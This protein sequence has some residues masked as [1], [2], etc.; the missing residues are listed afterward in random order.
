MTCV[1][2]VCEYWVWY[3]IELELV[4]LLIVLMYF[5]FVVCLLYLVKFGLFKVDY[6]FVFCC[7]VFEY[8][9]LVFVLLLFRLLFGFC[10]LCYVCGLVACYWL[11]GIPWMGLI[12]CCWGVC[13]WMVIVV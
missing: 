12:V 5:R 13:D 6:M 10:Y 9:C 4:V 7:I 11:D 2:G 8:D 1:N 3:V